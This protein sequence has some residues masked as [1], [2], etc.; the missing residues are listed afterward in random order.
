MNDKR[1]DVVGLGNAIVDVLAK[2][3]DEFLERHDLVKGSMALIDE[4]Q[5]QRIYAA[6]PPA[7]EASGG[8]AANTLAGLASFGARCGF[9]GKVKDD[10]LGKIFTHDIRAI[11]VD[12]TTSPSSAGAET[13]RCFVSVTPDAE[14]TMATFLGATRLIDVADVDEAMIKNAQ[15]LYL[16]GYLWDEPKAKEAMRHAMLVARDANTKVAF[17]LSDLFCVDRHRED[18]HVMLQSGMV[19]ILF[20]NE[21]E[22]KALFES[23]DD[24]VAGQEIVQYCD[25]VA[26]TR[27]GNGSILVT[28]DQEIQIAPIEVEDVVDTTGAGDLYAS[29]LLYGLSQD[30]E[31]E[32]C[33][34]LA[35]IAA[36]EIISHMGARPDQNLA[37]LAADLGVIEQAA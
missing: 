15:I 9:I 20:A 33:G 1:Y 13:A 10:E 3:E 17:S 14:R 31:L 35:S 19:D 11:G 18:F 6:M 28:K 37:K 22:A 8:S 30:Y 26:I 12:Y 32:Q 27:S 29:G 36:A 25:L 34:K 4:E 5:A 23:P 24:G 2:V 21:A 7:Q 16:E